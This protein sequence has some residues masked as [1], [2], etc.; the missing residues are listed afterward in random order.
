MATEVPSPIRCVSLAAMAGSKLV[1]EKNGQKGVVLGLAGPQGGEAKV[2]G[3][4]G[5]P[6]YPSEVIALGPEGGVELHGIVLGD[7]E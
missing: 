4:A 5:G 6:V 7:Q 3:H 1:I 2:F